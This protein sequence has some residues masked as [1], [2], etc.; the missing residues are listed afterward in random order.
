MCL[1][2]GDFNQNCGDVSEFSP[3]SSSSGYYVFLSILQ[4]KK[5]TDIYM[6]VYFQYV[7]QEHQEVFWKY[8]GSGSIVFT[9]SKSPHKTRWNQKT[10]PQKTKTK[11]DD[12]ISP[13]TLKYKQNGEKP[14]I[15]T[16]SS[17]YQSR[18]QGRRKMQQRN[19]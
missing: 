19:V 2:E 13:Q 11:L 16:R 1:N 14:A 9:I 15:G 17:Q 3:R 10:N 7:K 18:A 4:H 12:M 6:P 5:F 8:G